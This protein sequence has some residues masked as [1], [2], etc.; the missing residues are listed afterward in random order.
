MG[1]SAL[2]FDGPSDPGRDA[3]EARATVR[4][5]IW[6]ISVARFAAALTA[7][8]AF[9]VTGLAS[10]AAGVMVIALLAAPSR[11]QRLKHAFWQPLGQASLL[12]IAVLGL[13]TAWSP[14]DAKAALREWIGWRQFFW[15]FVALALFETRRSKV[16]FMALFA[17]ATALTACV[18]I[19]AWL[20]TKYRFSTPR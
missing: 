20:A 17:S 1:V 3:G 18:S 8:G 11:W 10:A 6:A 9:V 12:V 4:R 16:V 13:A 19:G 5:D 2:S 14:L 15:L 7:I